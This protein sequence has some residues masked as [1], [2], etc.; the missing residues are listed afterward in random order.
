M[1]RKISWN[2]CR[3][4]VFASV[5]RQFWPVADAKMAPSFLW[6]ATIQSIESKPDLA[7]LPPEDRFIR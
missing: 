6:F 7:D 3:G 5:G 4:I 1:S 2:V